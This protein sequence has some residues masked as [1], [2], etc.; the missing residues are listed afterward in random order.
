MQNLKVDI[1]V[2]GSGGAGLTAAITAL[3]YGASVACFEKRPFQGGAVSNCPIINMAVKND[4]K[5][6]AKAFSSISIL[7]IMQVIRV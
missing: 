6:Q 2:M 4:P 7:Q 3:D 5:Y 1:V